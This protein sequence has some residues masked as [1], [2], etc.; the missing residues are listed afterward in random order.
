[1]TGAGLALKL[2]QALFSRM[3]RP[4]PGR[5]LQ[6]AAL[7]TIAD[8]GAL[9]GENRVL[10]KLGLE[11]LRTTTEPGIAALAAMAGIELAA[12]DSEALSFSIIPR[13]NAAGRL[14]HA[15][16]SLDL[17]TTRDADQAHR[18]AG[19]LDRLNAERQKITESAM[20]EARRQLSRQPDAP[21]LFVGHPDWLPGILGL[22][23][24]RLA[25]EN[26]RPVVAIA[27]GEETS[28]ASV[29]SIPQVDIHAALN[30][31]DVTFVR[32]GG[33]A[34]AAGFTVA[35]SDMERLKKS[36]AGT[37][38]RQL[39]AGLPEQ[40]IEYDCEV[41]L[42]LLQGETMDFLHAL[43]PHGEGNPEPV[44]L[45]RAM[46][47][48]DARL[49]GQ[50]GRHLK[51]RVSQYGAPVTDAIAF[52][53]GSRYALLPNRIDLLYTI[54]IDTWGGRPRTQLKVVD[55]RPAGI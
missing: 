14:G 31:A 22:V 17:L 32:F 28:R 15:S 44:F 24:G 25:E 19:T 37:V 52:R 35:S 20:A 54:G 55:F 26:R 29:R 13:L 48:M 46:R 38:S 9:V 53:M 3:G 45:S 10:V 4:I 49:V 12:I 6:M 36:L 42:A 16:S 8:V 11:G 2:A 1:L 5:L 40:A 23:A 33:H 30:N 27:M 43:A 34:Q 39:S 47:V 21:V 18:I 51:M 41:P 50:E 7:G